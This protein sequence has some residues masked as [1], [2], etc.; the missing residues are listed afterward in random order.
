MPN[1]MSPDD[2]RSLWQ[3][4]EMEEETITIDAVRLQAARFER[5][6][7]RRNLREYAAGVAV[8]AFFTLQLWRVHG[9]GLA[10]PVLLIVGTIYVM[11][12]LHRLGARSLPAD[13]GITASIE[14]YCLEL[15]RQRDAL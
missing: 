10:P 12:Q 5:R 2:P 11:F 6:V 1:E 3:N 8:V 7:H 15:E 13:A 4:Q 9:W 14:F